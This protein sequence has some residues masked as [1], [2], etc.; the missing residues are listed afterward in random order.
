MIR[1]LLLSISD[2]E[3]HRLR[4]A[5]Q[6]SIEQMRKDGYEDEEITTYEEV[7]TTL[8]NGNSSHIDGIKLVLPK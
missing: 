6:A 8:Q 2:D 4:G 7:Y 3:M 1:S 5:M